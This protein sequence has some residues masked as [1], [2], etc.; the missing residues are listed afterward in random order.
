MYKCIRPFVLMNPQLVVQ[1]NV[2]LIMI[3]YQ[4]LISSHFLA[5]WKSVPVSGDE[6][7]DNFVQP[8][9]G[10]SRWIQTC[11]LRLLPC[12]RDGRQSCISPLLCRQS[13]R[14]SSSWRSGP[15]AGPRTPGSGSRSGR[16]DWGIFIHSLSNI[17]GITNRSNINGYSGG[18]N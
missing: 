9:D 13:G 4:V 16:G 7:F 5:V 14:W 15:G 6:G 3:K 17:P 8:Y 1:H 10:V 2:W 11:Y 12:R 18:L